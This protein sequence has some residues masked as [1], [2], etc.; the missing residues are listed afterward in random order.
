AQQTNLNFAVISDSGAQTGSGSYEQGDTSIGDIRI[1][2]YNFGTSTLA[3]AYLPP[4][5]NNYSIAGDF[6]FNTNQVFNIGSTYDLWTVTAHE[7][8]HALGLLHSTTTSSDV[9]WGSYNTLKTSL[10]TDD[11][12]GIKAIY[13]TLPADGTNT[14][15]SS[16]TDLSSQIDPTTLAAVVTGQDL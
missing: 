13:G 1:G 14:G 16:A 2:G 15:F 4:Q 12:N 9:M 6:D 3:S 11:S 10:N 8:G 7:F 5:V